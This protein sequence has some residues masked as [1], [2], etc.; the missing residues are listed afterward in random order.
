MHVLSL[1]IYR[2]H[3]SF[4]L[5]TG[6]NTVISRQRWKSR[7]ALITRVEQRAWAQNKT[8]YPIETPEWPSQSGCLFFINTQS[9]GT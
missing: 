3:D 9:T 2:W 8:K 4:F 5:L 7:V 1:H 6:F